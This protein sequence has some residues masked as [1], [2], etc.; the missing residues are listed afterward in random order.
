MDDGSY[1]LRPEARGHPGVL[2]QRAAGIVIGRGTSLVPKGQLAHFGLHLQRHADQVTRPAPQ[3][4][5][6]RQWL[7]WTIR[8][9][10]QLRT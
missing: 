4:Q 7:L 2:L 9:R 1:L 5:D 6:V 8:E 3:S 10:R